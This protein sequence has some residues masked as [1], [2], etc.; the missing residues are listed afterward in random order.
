[1]AYLTSLTLSL[2]FISWLEEKDSEA[3]G[4][5]RATIW[6]ELRS[7]SDCLE[8]FVIVYHVSSGLDGRG[9]KPLLH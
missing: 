9:I 7:L 4:D 1:M 5:N 8:Q 6:K 3:L 2:L